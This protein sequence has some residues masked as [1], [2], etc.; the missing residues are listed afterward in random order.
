VQ[1]WC[2]GTP[3]VPEQG[4][5]AAGWTWTPPID[6]VPGTGHVRLAVGRDFGDVTPL[7]GVIRG[8]GDHT[9]TRGGEHPGAA[10]AGPVS[11]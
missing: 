9:L 1:V 11:C 4:P 5:G 6:L 7:R 10:P 3:G 2:P 8:S